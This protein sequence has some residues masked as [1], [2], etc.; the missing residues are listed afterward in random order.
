M[1]PRTAVG[2]SKK[3]KSR[4]NSSVV[5]AQKE[6]AHHDRNY[7]KHAKRRGR[8]ARP[9]TGAARQSLPFGAQMAGLYVGSSWPCFR[10]PAINDMGREFSAGPA[11]GPFFRVPALALPFRNSLQPQDGFQ[12]PARQASSG[13]ATSVRDAGSGSRSRPVAGRKLA[14]G[15]IHSTTGQARI[16]G[17]Q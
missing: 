3:R 9:G 4:H 7:T 17:V 8:A 1:T 11:C 6:S 14:V 13:A 15:G 12:I 16:R 10:R 2:P 5:E